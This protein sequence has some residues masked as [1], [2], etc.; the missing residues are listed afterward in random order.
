MPDKICYR[1]IREVKYYQA[2]KGRSL[3]LIQALQRPEQRHSD[4]A[5]VFPL[6]LNR[7]EIRRTVTR[8]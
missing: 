8:P 3:Q 5:A 2:G 1:K 4:S 7:P 6:P